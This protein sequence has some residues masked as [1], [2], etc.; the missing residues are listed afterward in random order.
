VTGSLEVVGAIGLFIP[1]AA[2]FAALLLAS[3]MAGATATHLFF[4]GGSPLPAIVLL[5][6]AIGIAYLR[7]ERISSRL[8][9]A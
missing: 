9:A 7:R 2:P 6:S 5:A 1:A 8:L 4:V 3:V